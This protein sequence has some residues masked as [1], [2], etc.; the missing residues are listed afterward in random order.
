LAQQF[1]F[2]VDY[3]DSLSEEY[4]MTLEEKQASERALKEMEESLV[5]SYLQS[6][7]LRI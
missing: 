3:R 4:K 6:A 2:I 5:I 7:F 1:E